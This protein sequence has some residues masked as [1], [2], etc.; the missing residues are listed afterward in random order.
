MVSVKEEMDMIKSYVTILNIRYENQIL[1]EYEIEPEIEQ[2]MILKLTLQP[3]VENAVC[4]GIRLKPGAGKLKIVCRRYGQDQ[5]ELS[6]WDNGVGME[7]QN[8]QEVL[9]GRQKR[10]GFGLQSVRQRME[11][12]YG[13][14]GLVRLES[15]AGHW[16]KV[17][18]YAMRGIRDGNEK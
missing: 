17:T 5:M 1:L 11:L 10:S 4:H 13:K 7:R 18:V 14:T 16:T 6:V 9:Y 8:M 12:F 15:E 2:E 3:L